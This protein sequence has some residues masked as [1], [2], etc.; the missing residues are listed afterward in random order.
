ML[1][2]L[3][4]LAVH[5]HSDITHRLLRDISRVTLL[6]QPCALTTLRATTSLADGCPRRLAASGGRRECPPRLQTNR[7]DNRFDN[8]IDNRLYHVNEVFEY[9]QVTYL[10]INSVWFQSEELDRRLVEELKR[11]IEQR[12]AREAKR[13]KKEEQ[14]TLTKLAYRLCWNSY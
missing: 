1:V 12:L 4:L 9:F 3:L 6:Q 14:V 7:P 13:I 10:L 5:T 11:L 8:R 2:L